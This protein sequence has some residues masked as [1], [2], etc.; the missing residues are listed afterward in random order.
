[1]LMLFAV[2]MALLALGAGMLGVLITDFL[3]ALPTDRSANELL[4]GGVI[5]G[6]LVIVLSLR[7]RLQSRPASLTAWVPSL[8]HLY[9]LGAGLLSGALLNNLFLLA[10][11]LLM[12]LISLYIH[13]PPKRLALS[14]DFGVL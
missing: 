3:I 2:V 7:P 12:F 14:K 4:V 13:R 8:A 5:L 6:A 9:F 11:S 10:V 1:M